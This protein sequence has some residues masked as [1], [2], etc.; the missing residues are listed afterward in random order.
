VTSSESAVQLSLF[1]IDNY[2]PW[3]VTP[4]PRQ[5][6]DLQSLQAQLYADLADFVGQYDG[7][8]FYDRFDNMLGITNGMD[9]ETHRRFQRQVRNRYP[10]TLSIGVGVGATPVDALGLASQQLQA[11]GSAQD[12]ERT[13]ILSADDGIADTTDDLTIAH[14][15][16][17]DVTG[18]YTDRQNAATTTIAIQRAT[19][20]LAS[21]LHD[22]LDS[23]ARFV[24]GDNIIAVCPPLP[25]GS[26]DAARDHVHDLTGMDFQVGVG[27]GATAHGAGHRAKLALEECRESGSRIHRIAPQMTTD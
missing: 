26:L 22:E 13:E 23:I 20:E 19:V 6:T 8:V 12:P 27:R 16:V 10:V 3:T 14:F 7:Y 2:G 24:G 5:E 17:V 1:Q 15:D 11:D 4:S 9:L 18:S 21:Y 25:G